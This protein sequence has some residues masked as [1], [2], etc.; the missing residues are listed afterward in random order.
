MGTKK[1]QVRKT[2]RR[3]YEPKKYWLTSTYQ[4]GMKRLTSEGMSP[5]KASQYLRSMMS[6]AGI[7]KKK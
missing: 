7:L 1:G 6:D 5:A 4:K 2:A 3:A